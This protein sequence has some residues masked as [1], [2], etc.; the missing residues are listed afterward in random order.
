MRCLDSLDELR[1][2]DNDHSGCCCHSETG[3]KTN[4]SPVPKAAAK[5]LLYKAG[6]KALLIMKSAPLTE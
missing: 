3:E 5:P 2:L 4:G 1:M 6:S